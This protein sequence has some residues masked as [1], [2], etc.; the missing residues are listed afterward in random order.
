MKFEKS[1]LTDVTSL[2]NVNH[3]TPSDKANTQKLDRCANGILATFENYPNL[4]TTDTIRDLM[5]TATVMEGEIAAARR[6]Y[7]SQSLQFNQKIQT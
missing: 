6:L 1:L 3:F 7:N 4:K 5:Q 2:R